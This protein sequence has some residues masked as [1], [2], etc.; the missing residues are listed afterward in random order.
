MSLTLLAIL[1]APLYLKLAIDPSGYMKL[2]KETG[3]SQAVSTAYGLILGMLALMIF[4]TTG[5]EFGFTW[6]HLLTW[7][8]A[9]IFIKGAILILFPQVLTKSSKWLKEET[10][11]MFAFLGLLMLFALV[12]V[13]TQ[14]L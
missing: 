12:Y 11:P 3:K 6:E 5:L 10:L 2:I 4:M 13:D 14:V 9:L 1:L 7:L 8:G